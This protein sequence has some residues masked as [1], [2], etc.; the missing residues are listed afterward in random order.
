MAVAARWRR[1]CSVSSDV[2]RA[3][4]QRLLKAS[5]ASA[6]IRRNQ[7]GRH[8]P[9]PQARRRSSPAGVPLDAGEHRQLSGYLKRPLTWCL[10]ADDGIRTRDPNLG[11]VLN[12]LHRFSSRPLRCCLV[13]TL[14]RF[15]A[16]VLPC[17][18]SVNYKNSST[19]IHLQGFL[20]KE[21]GEF[22]SRIDV[23]LVQR[24]AGSLGQAH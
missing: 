9:N 18:R 8:T 12:A 5:G 10:F 13:R 2:P 17:F 1:C 4:A 6:S 14:T 7:R 21:G 3:A 22:P 16:P 23:P 11:N 15:E 19:R 20:A 24:T